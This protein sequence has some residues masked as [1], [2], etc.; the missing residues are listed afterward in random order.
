M[1]QAGRCGVVGCS[2]IAGSRGRV[3]VLDP[4]LRALCAVTCAPFTESQNP[5]TAWVGRDFKD[6]ESPTPLPGRATNLPIY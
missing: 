6:H 1:G 5:R 3:M 2:P 4:K